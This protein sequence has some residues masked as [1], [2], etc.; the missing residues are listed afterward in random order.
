MDGPA[1]EVE[2]K[3]CIAVLVVSTLSVLGGA[4]MIS[5]F[6]VVPSLRTFRHQLILGL[7]ISDFMMA[8][9]V[10]LSTSMNLAGRHIWAEEQHAFCSFNG[11]MNQMFVIQTD[12]WILIIAVCTY[13]ILMDHTSAASW[14]QEYR[15]LL[16][17]LP[18]LLST[19]WATLGLLLVGYGNIGAWC[20]FTSDRTRLLVN[21]TP[22]WIII[23]IILALYT[24][25]CIFLYRSHQSISSDYETSAGALPTELQQ[26][27]VLD[28]QAEISSDHCHSV[29]PGSSPLK[30]I[31]RRMMI[32]PTVYALIW[33]VP[34]AV[35]I[36]HG[37]TGRHV[38]LALRIVDNSCIISH[39]LA[40]AIIYGF[41]ERVRNGW[42]ERCS[43]RKTVQV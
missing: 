34:T 41:N 14:I 36:Y 10:V 12:Y 30:N 43:W 27:Q 3:L 39:G 17:C 1:S 24:R 6:I 28:G 35:R 42:M 25:L 33:V 9:N 15:I 37:A 29:Y 19:L 38:P 21:F 8:L 18:W 4:W 32:Y 26:W 31:S 13:L 5:S 16:W 11:F 22:R 40:D 20:W 2:R 23:L 7:G